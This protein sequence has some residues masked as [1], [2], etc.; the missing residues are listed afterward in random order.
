[1][2]SINDLF[3]KEL[4]VVNI[5]MDSF[6]DNLKEL[7]YEVVQVDWAPPAGGDT[8]VMDALSLLM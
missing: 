6:K 3:E 7:G 5:G 4:K 1:M 2:S 8:N